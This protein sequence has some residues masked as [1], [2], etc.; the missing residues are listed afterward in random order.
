M[1]LIAE[2]AMLIIRLSLKDRKNKCREETN[3]SIPVVEPGAGY[4]LPPK[5]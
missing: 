4:C 2:P 3:H 1:V 5:H